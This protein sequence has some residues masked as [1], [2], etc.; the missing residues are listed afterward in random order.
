MDFGTKNH[1]FKTLCKYY[2][3]MCGGVV[4]LFVLGTRCGS[5]PV[6]PLKILVNMLPQ[7]Q[8]QNC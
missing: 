4:S 2:W 1:E 3:G 7:E 6:F 8:V 5:F